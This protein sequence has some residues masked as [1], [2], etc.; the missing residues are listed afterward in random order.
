MAKK[1]KAKKELFYHVRITEHKDLP[2]RE[3]I[4][5]KKRKV[6]KKIVKMIARVIERDPMEREIVTADYIKKFKGYET[7]YDEGNVIRYSKSYYVKNKEE[8]KV[9]LQRA[10]KHNKKTKRT[11]ISAIAQMIEG[12]MPRTGEKL[13]AG[14]KLSKTAKFINVKRTAKQAT[15][16]NRFVDFENDLEELELE[17][18]VSPP[19]SKKGRK[20]KR[21]N[22]NK[23]DL[24]LSQQE[25]T[26]GRI[27]E[28]RKERLRKE[29][30]TPRKVTKAEREQFKRI[31]KKKER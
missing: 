9:L 28:S 8:A 23:K 6:T 11:D 31:K 5:F 10:I 19:P 27:V 2:K 3:P 16:G 21:K 4:P 13:K 25:R 17:M 18:E 15:K 29:E 26:R 14:T 7:I 24:K 30:F 20:G 1:R 12:D 22:V